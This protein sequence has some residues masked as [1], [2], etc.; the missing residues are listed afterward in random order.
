MSYGNPAAAA[1]TQLP[2][3]VAQAYQAAEQ[4]GFGADGG[5]S[6]CQ[7]GVGAL[8]RMLAASRPGGIVAELGTGVGAGAAWLLEGLDSTGR[9][10]SAEIDPVRAGLARELVDDPRATLI[11][12]RWQD[13]LPALAP[14]DLVFLDYGWVD[15]HEVD[16][17]AL[18]DLVAIGGYLVM[19]DVTPRSAAAA[20]TVSDPKRSLGL[21]HPRLVGVEIYP[22]GA[23]R[24][25][26]RSPLGRHRGRQGALSGRVDT[27]AAAC[28]IH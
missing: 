28:P 21:G 1:S 24:V 4:I 16:P 25:H 2:P 11:E 9:L 12:G 8:L 6:S 17:E 14:F 26:R 7:P 5:L 19:D 13:H 10:V 27:H 20:G 15:D 22:A 18:I 3:R 23:D